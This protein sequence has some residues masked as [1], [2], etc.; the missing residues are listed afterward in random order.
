MSPWP[1]TSHLLAG[2]I[3]RSYT[4]LKT[5]THSSILTVLC[6]VCVR[7]CVRVC[8]CAKKMERMTSVLVMLV[9]L[10]IFIQ[11]SQAILCYH[12]DPCGSSSPSTYDCGGDVCVKGVGD[13][14]GECCVIVGMIVNKAAQQCRIALRGEIFMRANLM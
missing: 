5:A 7:A 8:V 12:C 3:S 9:T 11:S 10:G 13:Y 1:E 6:V 4:L 2:Y 14:Y